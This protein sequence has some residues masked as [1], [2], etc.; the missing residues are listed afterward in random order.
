MK[1]ETKRVLAFGTLAIAAL[2]ALD[3]GQY[4]P[5]ANTTPLPAAEHTV[6]DV[7]DPTMTLGELQDLATQ[8]L[9]GKALQY[10]RDCAAAPHANPA[11]CFRMFFYASCDDAANG[12]VPNFNDAFRAS[13]ASI[14]ITVRR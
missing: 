13:C 1:P 5:V 6:G 11:G 4:A 12:R 9:P 14:N 7:A 10:F 8:V 2:I 3:A